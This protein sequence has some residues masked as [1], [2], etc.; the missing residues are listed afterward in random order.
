MPSLILNFSWISWSNIEELSRRWTPKSHIQ[1]KKEKRKFVVVSLYALHKNAKLGNFT[2]KSQGCIDGKEV[3]KKSVVWVQS[4]FSGALVAVVE[5]ASGVLSQLKT[6]WALF[7]EFAKLHENMM[8]HFHFIFNL[9]LE[10][11]SYYLPKLCPKAE[12][13]SRRCYERKPRKIKTCAVIRHL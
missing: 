8:L 9:E 7:G 13:H 3:Y 1:V 12:A 4:C 2:S 11:Q 5:T 10:V 6:R